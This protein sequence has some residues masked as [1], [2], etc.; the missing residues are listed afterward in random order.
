M[1]ISPLTLKDCQKAALLHQGA[2]LK[3][4]DAKTFREF[5]RNPLVHGLK[6]GENHELYGYIL[7]REMGDEAEILT[8]VVAS[9]YQRMGKGTFLLITLIKALRIK[10][11]TNLFLEVAEDNINA[12]SFY[13]KNGFSLLSI[14]PHYYPREGGKFIAA[15][16]FFKKLI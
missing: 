1:P 12:Q 8:F 7:W 13:L 16:N 4:W 5:L 15:L 10:N 9:S 11:I 6:I 2:F 14:R 3:G